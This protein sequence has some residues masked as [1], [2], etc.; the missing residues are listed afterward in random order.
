MKT[1]SLLRHAEA[2][3]SGPSLS[4]YDRPLKMRGE[5]D[6]ELMGGYLYGLNVQPG[7]IV[8]SPA[9]RAIS[10]AGIVA[11]ALHLDPGQIREM[12]SIY[13]ASVNELMNVV[14]GFDDHL[15]HVM[16]VGHNP[17]L[18]MLA[19]ILTDQGYD[20]PTCAFLSLKLVIDEWPDLIPGVGRE[21]A[22]YRPGQ[23][24][25]GTA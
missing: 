20:L 14:R 18:S 21:L 17:G 6:A 12:P 9:L 5:Q 22:F 24:H 3:W 13:E 15:E 8:S 2:S 4:D 7:Q 11:V 25:S 16:L 19:R 23:I 1:L 10:T